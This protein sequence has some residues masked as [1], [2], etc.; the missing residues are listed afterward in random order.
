MAMKITNE[1]LEGYLNCKTKGHLKLVGETGDKSDFAA[2]TEANSRASREMSLASLLAHSG[3]GNAYRGTAITAATLKQGALLLVDATIDDDVK[4]ICFDG[5]K[6]ADGPS[7]LGGHHYIPVLHNHDDKIDRQRKL[8]LAVL[9]LVLDGVQG[10]RP[11][12][13][14]VARG[15]E[16]R[17][18]KVRL[19]AKLY[20]EA[21]QVL[22]KARRLQAG[23]EPPKLALN[24]HCQVCEFRQSCRK[25]AVQSDD[26]SLL[27][28]VGEKELKRYNSKGIFTVTQLSCTFRPRKRA[29]R[30]KRSG[31]NRY[32][33]LQA[34]AIR[35]KKVY[36][37][38]TPDFP[39][40]P[41]QVF[42][43]A[44]GSEDGGFA[45]LLGVLVVE[46]R[47]PADAL[48]LGG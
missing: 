21:E 34:L 24:R 11:A 42:L 17:L 3:E 9:G 12:M 2:M 7:K 25:Q 38:G 6:R 20:R 13:G 39:R 18:G 44:E 22:D 29:K 41:M 33:A 4:S 26:I 40:K 32:L 30:V 36:V 10:L 16:G 15:A 5:L 45:Y 48:L 43:D 19:D 46:G 1:V 35:E 37:Y 14:L 23:G 47:K 28:S 31:Y 8:L 27:G